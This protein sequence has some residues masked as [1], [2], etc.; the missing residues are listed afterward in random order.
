VN[1][2]EFIWRRPCL[3]EI[4]GY[5]EGLKHQIAHPD[6]Y[7]HGIQYPQLTP[8]VLAPIET[9][10]KRMLSGKEIPDPSKIERDWVYQ[11]GRKP[12]FKPKR[13]PR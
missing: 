12:V 1:V 3:E 7:P 9:Y 11:R 4:D 8:E 10:R 13:G 6:K 5:I 2:H